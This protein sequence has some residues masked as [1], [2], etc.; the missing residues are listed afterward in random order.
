MKTRF[1]ILTW[2]FILP[3]TLFSQVI[4]EKSSAIFI[5]KS[6]SSPKEVVTRN[7]IMPFSSAKSFEIM[8]S[9]DVKKRF[10]KSENLAVYIVTLNPNVK[11]IRIEEF[12]KRKKITT[13]KQKG[14]MVDGNLISNTSDAL[15]EESSVTSIL[16]QGDKVKLET[17]SKDKLHGLKQRPQ[18][19]N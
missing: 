18:L 1:V 16:L 2:A 7:L 19:I 9:L 13:G 11:L 14:L 17:L 15:I 3:I 12:Y 6:D 5:V 8:S 10:P 4:Q